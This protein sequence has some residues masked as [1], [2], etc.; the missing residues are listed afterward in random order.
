MRAKQLLK[1]SS[2]LSESPDGRQEERDQ[3][4]MLMV[5]NANLDAGYFQEQINSLGCDLLLAKNPKEA[6]ALAKYWKPLVIIVEISARNTKGFELF[7]QLKEDA[8]TNSIPFLFISED[9]TKPDQVLGF[10]A[11]AD[12]YIANPWNT[13]EL[14]SRLMAL[15]RRRRSDGGAG[16]YVDIA[17]R[18]G[19]EARSEQEDGKEQPTS[20]KT[21]QEDFDELELLTSREKPR[22]VE[23]PEER[24]TAKRTA[25]DLYKHLVESLGKVFE[26][27]KETERVNLNEVRNLPKPLME[28]LEQGNDLLL[29]ALHQKSENSLIYDSLNTAIY[30]FLVGKGLN[31]SRTQL[32]EL[33][34]AALLNDIGFVKLPEK[35]VKQ[36][37]HLTGS[38]IEMIQE[39]PIHAARIIKNSLQ[40][41]QLEEHRW[42]LRAVIQAHEREGGIG[43][44]KGLKGD[45]ISEYAKIIGIAYTFETLLWEQ[46]YKK[47]SVTYQALQKIISMDHRYFSNRIKKAL[48]TQISI[49]PVGTYVK[50]NSEEIG[51]VVET[52][53]QHPMRPVIELLYNA[54]GLL[55]SECERKNLRDTPFLF[56]TEVLAPEELEKRDRTF[57]RNRG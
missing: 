21:K 33:T 34:L 22:S 54:K 40:E 41:D 55:V 35:L 10:Q 48:V 16:A 52:N 19:L 57:D 45:E 12:D 38:E 17:T 43:Y 18:D 36:D 2:D 15:V 56:I 50:L 37:E 4:K 14:K 53:L 39:H 27:A 20:Q 49:F 3:E 11:G 7:R 25:H 31:Y 46:T 30:S 8:R 9:K 13:K 24:E 44:P 26:S 42:L 51:M 23:S 32:E 47:G 28:S 6:I 5:D 1:R 29:Q